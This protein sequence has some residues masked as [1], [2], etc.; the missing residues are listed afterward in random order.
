M[1]S[2]IANNQNEIDSVTLAQANV[3]C[4]LLIQTVQGKSCKQLMKM[5][6][7]EKMEVLKHSN[8]RN[9]VCT[10]CGVKM[11]LNKK[12]ADQVLVCPA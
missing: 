1:K 9:M 11:A 3:G 12:L 7:C 4:R 8:G 6:F 2:N 5:G 10:V